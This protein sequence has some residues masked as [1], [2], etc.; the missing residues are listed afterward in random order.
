M[1]LN[2]SFVVESAADLSLGA[3]L[4]P[5]QN[6]APYWRLALPSLYLLSKYHFINSLFIFPPWEKENLNLF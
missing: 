2:Q 1:A 5:K 4:V 6:D 3:T